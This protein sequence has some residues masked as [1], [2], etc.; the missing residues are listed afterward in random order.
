[1][2]LSATMCIARNDYHQSL[3]S[4]VDQNNPDETLLSPNKGYEECCHHA[5]TCITVTPS[6]PWD[7]YG[8]H[9]LYDEATGDWMLT[10]D[11][12]DLA[13]EPLRPYLEDLDSNVG[14]VFGNLISRWEGRNGIENNEQIRYN[15]NEFTPRTVNEWGGG[16]YALKADAWNDIKKDMHTDYMVHGDSRLF[17]WLLKNDWDYYHIP[18]FTE[19]TYLRDSLV[20]WERYT[21]GWN[22][23]FEYLERGDSPEEWLRT[24]LDVSKWKKRV[25]G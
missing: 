7:V 16:Y 5:D 24:D 23:V 22:E 4:L 21:P 17:Y 3:N 13:V 18:L 15:N 9:R 20:E 6:K 10:L 1:M 8:R 11:D 2:K 19:I 25:H 12:D 14:L